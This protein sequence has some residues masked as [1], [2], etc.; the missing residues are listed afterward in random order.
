MIVFVNYVD[1]SK[2]LKFIFILIYIF[3]IYSCSLFQPDSKDISDNIFKFSKDSYYITLER[4]AIKENGGDDASMLSYEKWVRSAFFINVGDAYSINIPYACLAECVIWQY[5][6]NHHVISYNILN[7]ELNLHD[8]CKFVRFHIK[9]SKLIP[10]FFINIIGAN[11][12]PTEEK[13]VQMSFPYERLVYEINDSVYTTALLMLPNNYC[14]NGKSVPLIVWDSGDGSFQNWDSYEGGGY[15]GRLK[16]IRY[17]RDQGFAVL[18]I[19][20]WGSY[21]YKKYPACGYRSAM[22]IPTHLATHEKGV[23]YILSRYNI[24]SDNIFHVSKSGSG[25]IALYYALNKPSFNLKSIYAFAP[26]FD[27][28]NFVGWRLKDYRYAL[29]E[30]LNFIGSREEINFFLNGKP[31]DYDLFYANKH[32]LKI[33]L[34]S[35]WQM[36]TPL[37][38]SFIKKNSKKFYAISVDWMNMPYLTDEQKINDTH[39]FSEEFWNGYNRYYDIRSGKF[40]FKW[41]NINI[42]KL[43]NYTYNR[44]NLIRSG[45]HIPLV[46]IMSP[47]DEQTP[48]WNALEVVTQMQNA[49]EEA[50]M[51]TLETGGHSGPDMST[52]GLNVKLNVITRLGIYYEFVPIGFYLTVEDI[53]NRFL[54]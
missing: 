4:G 44:Y 1:M 30:E 11:S 8:E 5:D 43:R 17:L 49:G 13:R 53:Y 3:I 24:D 50:K 9:S 34:D 10:G 28:L 23:A 18:E 12:K 47:T 14:H 32:N 48:Y 19:Y 46:V 25:K 40:Y 29:F 35:S 52:S 6:I 16:G 36:H 20:S 41:D 7:G 42:P 27:D 33:S 21:Y 2:L 54:N 22:P 31:Y 51:I 38:R 15:P 26:V 37:G 39:R 45:S